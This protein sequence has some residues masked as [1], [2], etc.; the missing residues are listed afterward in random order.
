MFDMFYRGTSKSQ[1]TGLG[2]FIVKEMI[3]KLNGNIE[4]ESEIDVGTTF[5]TT[6]PKH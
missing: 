4:V 2:L 6:I 5:T 1:G 3:E